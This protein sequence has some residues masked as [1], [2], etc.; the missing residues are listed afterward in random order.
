MAMTDWDRAKRLSQYL[1]D[2]DGSYLFCSLDRMDDPQGYWLS[3]FRNEAEEHGATVELR[4]GHVY[5]KFAGI[6]PKWCSG[7]V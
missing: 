5:V 1:A 2:E 7:E 3:A 6:D 4:N